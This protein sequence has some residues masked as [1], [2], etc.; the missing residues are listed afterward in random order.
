[1]ISCC[2]PR[3]Q[4]VVA[5]EQLFSLAKS[6][7]AS[8]VEVVAHDDRALAS[9]CG[10]SAAAS[11][12]C[13]ARHSA[14]LRAPTPGRFEVLQVLQRDLQVVAVDLQ[15]RPAASRA[16]SSSVWAGSRRRRAI[17]QQGDQPLVALGQVQQRQLARA[18]ARAGWPAAAAIWRIIVVLAVVV[19]AVAAVRRPRASSPDRLGRWPPTRFRFCEVVVDGSR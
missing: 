7:A 6:R 3:R 13:R 5:L 19:A 8:S 10:V 15:F 17:D 4:V 18:D 16:I 12:S 11:A 2:T 9:R 14:R 1:M